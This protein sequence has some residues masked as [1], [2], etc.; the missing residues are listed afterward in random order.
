[1]SKVLDDL[2]VLL[3]TLMLVQLLSQAI[4]ITPRLVNRDLLRPGGVLG[5]DRDLSVIIQSHEATVASDDLTVTV[6]SDDLGRA[7][8]EGRKKGL[9]TG[10]QTDITLGSPNNDIDRLPFH[11]SR[12]ALTTLT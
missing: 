4:A 12:S 2:W 3:G 8:R 6:R 10:E 11:T 7:R 5:D 1:M 9:M